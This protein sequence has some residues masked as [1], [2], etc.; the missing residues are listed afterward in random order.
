M[1]DTWICNMTRRE[2][3]DVE[4]YGRFPKWTDKWIELP[5][6]TRSGSSISQQQLKDMGLVGLYG[7][8]VDRP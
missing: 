8:E 3:F 6:K 7:F 2:C 1:T 5:Q 4:F